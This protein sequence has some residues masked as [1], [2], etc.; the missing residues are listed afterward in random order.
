LSLGSLRFSS[1]RLDS[2]LLSHSSVWF[3]NKSARL[4]HLEER[5]F[6]FPRRVKPEPIG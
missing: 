1:N 2:P 3:V 4:K 6:L 5:F